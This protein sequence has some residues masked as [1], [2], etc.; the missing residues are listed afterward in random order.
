MKFREQGKKIQVIAYVDYNKEKKQSVQKMIA[1]YHPYTF[2]VSYVKDEDGTERATPEMK[3][4]LAAHIAELKEKQAAK[5]HAFT[6]SGA[7]TDLKDCGKE[8]DNPELAAT[9]EKKIAS[10]PKENI[11]CIWRALMSLEKHLEAAGHAR[12][13]RS[14]KKE[15]APVS[16]DPRQIDLLKKV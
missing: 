12:P 13:K 8:I 1:T 7:L 14:Y 11:E 15:T 5:D 10:L 9:W 2:E 3:E 4:K 6:F 16:K